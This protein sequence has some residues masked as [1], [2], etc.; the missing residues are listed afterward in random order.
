MPQVGDTV[1]AQNQLRT[2]TGLMK[3]AEGRLVLA[4]ESDREKGVCMISLWNDWVARAK[5][6]GG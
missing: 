6:Y 1:F 2:V 3:N 5:K 4:W